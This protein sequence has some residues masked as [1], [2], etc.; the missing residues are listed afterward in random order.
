M[1]YGNFSQDKDQKKDVSIGNAQQVG[2]VFVVHP[3]GSEL[4]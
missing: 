4:C 3:W 1:K 2:K